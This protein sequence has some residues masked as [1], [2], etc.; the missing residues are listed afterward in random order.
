MQKKTEKS[1]KLLISI[2][3]HPGRL[4]GII[5][6]FFTD[7]QNFSYVKL[8]YIPYKTT[9][10]FLKYQQSLLNMIYNPKTTNCVLSKD[11]L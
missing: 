5:R 1:G 7:L 11:D 3:Q 10:L 6:F 8:I 9:K 2:S 4:L